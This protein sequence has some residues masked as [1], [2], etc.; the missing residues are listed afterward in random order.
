MRGQPTFKSFFF[1]L[2]GGGV[3]NSETIIPSVVCTYSEEGTIFPALDKRQH[4]QLPI[5]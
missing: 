3:L 2:G 4:Y 5:L 1:F